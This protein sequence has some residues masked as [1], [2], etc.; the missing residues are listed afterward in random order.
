MSDRKMKITEGESSLHEKL[1]GSSFIEKYSKPIEFSYE[2][3][4]KAKVKK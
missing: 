4:V 3:T 2:V 1:S